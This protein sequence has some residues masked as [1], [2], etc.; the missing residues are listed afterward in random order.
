M[1]KYRTQDE[2]KAMARNLHIKELEWLA[3]T[4]NRSTTLASYEIMIR[5]VLNAEMERRIANWETCQV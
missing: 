3:E 1:A 5:D 2:Y 4:F